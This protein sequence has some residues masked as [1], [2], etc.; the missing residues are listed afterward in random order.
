MG[1]KYLLIEQLPRIGD[2]WRIRYDA[3]K[4]HT[5][6][7]MDNFP[8]LHY[9]SNW[10]KN[11]PGQRVGDWMES[12]AR[13]L[14]LKALPGTTASNVRY[15]ASTRKYTVDLE[16][17][18]IKRTIKTRHI[19]MSMGLNSQD[20]LPMR[21]VTGQETFGGLRYHSVQHKSATLLPDVKNKSV[22]VIGAG[23][24]GHDI[25]KDFVDAGA[26]EVR[27]V[28]RNPIVYVSQFTL[29]T[30]LLPFWQPNSTRPVTE[31]DLLEMSASAAVALT[32]TAMVGP[33]CADYDKEMH[34]GLEKAGMAIRRGTDGIT[35]LDSLFC[36]N[37]HFYI[38]QGAGHMIVDGRIKVHQC[39]EGVKK[40]YEKGVELVDGTKIDSDVIVEATGFQKN[41]PRYEKLLGK[42]IADKLD[43]ESWGALDDETERVCVS[44]SA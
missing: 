40:Y 20:P 3:V 41:G 42:E 35:L 21:G 37:G 26:K 19:V 6:S 2:T 23:T 28:Q 9:P 4:T 30:F 38:E 7:Y 10:P 31:T 5:P 36:K 11:I 1:L 34:D 22:T 43:S 32:L 15:D 27:L 24:S 18:G 29:E 13:I 17:N 39:K 14:Q 33:M 44:A 16:T 25:A 8:F 12:Y